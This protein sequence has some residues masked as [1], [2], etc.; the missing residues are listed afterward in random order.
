MSIKLAR[1]ALS[2]SLASLMVVTISSSLMKPA[3]SS[4]PRGE[5][6]S[7]FDVR[8]PSEDATIKEFM[9]SVARSHVASL[10]PGFRLGEAPGAGPNGAGIPAP[11]PALSRASVAPRPVEPQVRMVRFALNVGPTPKRTPAA[12]ELRVNRAAA[13]D[14]QAPE[15]RNALNFVSDIGRSVANTGVLS[16]TT[17]FAPAMR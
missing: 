7:A 1:A 2:A 16:S 12:N 17:A 13:W 14:G 10:Q 15:V 9:E 3:D 8:S 5:R 4:S 11:V 6:Q